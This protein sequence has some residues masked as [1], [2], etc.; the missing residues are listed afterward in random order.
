VPQPKTQMFDEAIELLDRYCAKYAQHTDY[1]SHLAAEVK[2]RLRQLIFILQRV[3]KL[4]GVEPIAMGKVQTEGTKHAA[5]MT[6]RGITQQPAPSNL[7]E[8]INDAWEQ[9][10]A[11]ETEIRILTEAFY[12]FA[13]RIRTIARDSLPFIKFKANGVRDVR[14][15]LI[16]HSDHK[17]S[18]ILAQSFGFGGEH[19][20]V[21]KGGRPANEGDKFPDR[22]LYLN[23]DEF[24][25][26]LLR[27]FERALA[28]E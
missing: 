16:E 15:K 28:R 6:A 27:A 10:G 8:T 5:S 22:G 14:N 24:G 9:I 19:G 21:I 23:A 26:S 4:E 11:A 1:N 17:D 20:P 2:E 25:S 12:Y 18:R 13:E 3:S 7:V